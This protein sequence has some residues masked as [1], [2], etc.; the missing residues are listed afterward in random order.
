MAGSPK[1]RE[2][3]EKLVRRTAEETRAVMVHVLAAMAGGADLEEA[4]GI[5]GIPKTTA[6]RYLK[7]PEF[8]A[9]LDA[10]IAE[11]AGVAARKG[12]ARLAAAA[13]AAVGALVEIARGTK[14]KDGRYPDAHARVKAAMAILDRAG[15]GPRQAV[16]HVHHSGPESWDDA[17]LL[18]AK[19]KA[20]AVIDASAKA[21]APVVAVEGE[22]ED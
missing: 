6:R 12:R 11:A 1:K 20:S 16:D 7:R 17:R 9:M 15:L 22:L 14:Q 5:A 8:S 10:A 13:T 18:A 4:A 2:R 3:R 21:L 19:E